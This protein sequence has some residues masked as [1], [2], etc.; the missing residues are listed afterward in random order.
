M[1]VPRRAA[2]VRPGPRI[3][4][5]L[6]ARALFAIG[7]SAVSSSIYFALGLV[8]GDTLGLTPV[9]FLIAGAFFVVTMMSYIEGNTLHPERGGASTFARYAFNEL[10]SFVAGWAILLDYV[11]VMAIAAFAIPHYLSAFWGVTGDPV[12]EVL[13]AAAAIA[14][15]AIVNVRGL[16]ANR[17]RVVLRIGI[18]NVAL[19]LA[20]I[21]IGLVHDFDADLIFDGA[22]LP[23]WSDFLFGTVLAMAAVTGIEAASGL[24]AEIRPRAASLRRVVSLGAAVL[25]ILFLGMSVVAIVTLP[26]FGGVSVLG[27]RAA[28][29]PVLEVVSRYDPGWLGDA[30]RYAVGAVGAV[31]LLQAVTTGMLGLSR[32]V[33]SLATNRQVPAGLG[34]LHPARS[35]PYVAIA[36][37]AVVTVALIVP[38]DIDFLAGI[39]AFG[40]TL[41]FSIAHVSIIRLRFREPEMPRPYRVP[42]SVRAG[43]GSIPIPSLIGAAAAVAAWL[44]VIVLHRE[45]MVVGGLWMLAGVVL[46][47]AYRRAQGE[48]VFE[49]CVIP[50]EALRDRVEAAFGSILVPVFGGPL[51]DDIVGTAGRLAAEEREAGEGGAMIE[52]LYV[53]EMPMSVPIDARVPDERIAAARNA[54][55]RAK[56]VGEEYEGV[57]VATATS[58]SRSIGAAIVDEA[59]RRGVEAIVLAAEQ[60]T[61]VRGGALLGGLGGPRDRFLGEMTRYVLEKAP[62]RVILTAP[63]AGDDGAREG[64][65]P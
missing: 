60:P 42:L 14:F 10:W 37:A 40:A 3:N 51:D 53:L 8:A 32:L 43:A 48:P 64:V 26:P 30:L 35:T 56:E 24:A 29:A 61:R 13:I 12:V 38:S 16:S 28:E 65:A 22:D 31:V 49:R 20:V 23:G 7:L 27:G 54:L 45:A 18:L 1:K 63:P 25:G 62:C 5:A 52:A 47:V 11:I 57:E 36:L 2:A 21:V 4:R 44:S 46:Y 33:Y 34:K 19:L 15:V 9:A 41:T 55:A 58:R 6:G 39:F 50:A 17:L 59:R